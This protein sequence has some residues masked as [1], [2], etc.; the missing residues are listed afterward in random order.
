MRGQLVDLRTRRLNSRQKLIERR[1]SEAR[2]LATQGELTDDVKTQL[3]A[4]VKEHT[5]SVTSNITALGAQ[6]AD[7]AAI[8]RIAFSSSLEVQSAV[9]NASPESGQEST[10]VDSLLTVVNEARS[11]ASVAA[12]G[13]PAPSYAGLLAKVE[14]ETTRAYEL[15]ETVKH[16]ATTQEIQN[17]ER[18]LNDVN[19]LIGESK[20][21]Y[22]Q[23]AETD[24]TLRMA[25]TEVAQTPRRL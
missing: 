1:I 11:K 23:P 9:L 22:N 19:R 5:K 15:F 12:E 4:T 10:S 3:A 2:S 24:V 21:A 7:G 13:E 8:A 16:S 6:D 18:R 17:T 25:S 14:L 20:D